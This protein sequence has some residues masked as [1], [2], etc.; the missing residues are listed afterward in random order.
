MNIGITDKKFLV[1]NLV[2]LASLG[3]LLGFSPGRPMDDLFAA[4]AFLFLL[5]LSFIR[6]VLKEKAADYGF[7]WG[8]LLPNMV[9][10]AAGTAVF[11]LG[12]FLAARFTPFLAALSVPAALRA[13][14]SVF[15][16]YAW[17]SATYL[18]LYEFFFRGF[19]LG[20]W[21]RRVSKPWALGVQVAVFSGFLAWRTG[22]YVSVGIIVLYIWW[23]L[24]A[25]AVS[26]G[27]RSVF[28]SFV[29]SY[30]SAILG[31]VALILVS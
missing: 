20:V 24:C 4:I 15:L 12:I 14:F 13:D 29:L 8:D 25:G 21:E 31:A 11:W 19:F 1:S 17:M 23:S 28:P 5:P 10:I 26:Q 16:A 6:V 9:W 22:A 7:R 30:L 3:L 18:F 2:A 27:S